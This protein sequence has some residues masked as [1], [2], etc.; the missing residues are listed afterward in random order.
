MMQPQGLSA[1]HTDSVELTCI[2]YL[3]KYPSKEREA[4]LLIKLH[5]YNV[6]TPEPI[7][8]EHTSG[9]GMFMHTSPKYE[10]IHQSGLKTVSF[11]QK[12]QKTQYFSN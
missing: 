12:R 1:S 8:N 3:C 10:N 2:A 7:M 6:N 11:G 9:R 5:T 4:S